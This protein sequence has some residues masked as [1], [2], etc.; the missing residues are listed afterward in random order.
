MLE[1]LRDA[2]RQAL[3]NFHSELN[4]NRVPE[5]ADRLLRAMKDELVELRRRTKELQSELEAVREEAR[6][7]QEATKTCLRREEMARKIGDEETASVA[8]DFA[9]K[10][11]RRHE[12]LS[13]K[14]EVLG[15]E[16]A[17]RDKNLDEMMLQFREARL[18]CETLAARTGLTD[19]RESIRKTDDLFEE[20]DRF[21][22]RIEDLE[23]HAEAARD[24]GET[25]DPG[26]SSRRNGLRKDD[27]DAR[28]EALKRRLNEQ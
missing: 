11:L 15:E 1:S 2:F 25:F 26:S 16:L 18:R 19:S 20:M 21:A 12:I 17:D 6:H 13:E 5:A 4:R 10:H 14:A 8:R 3:K 22:E 9:E 28:L 23:A 7:E 24:L 27:L